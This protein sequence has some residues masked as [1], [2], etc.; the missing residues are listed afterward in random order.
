MGS[1]SSAF[2]V[3]YYSVLF[4][5]YVSF[6]SGVFLLFFHVGFRVSGLGLRKGEGIEGG[7]AVVL[8]V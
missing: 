4:Y 1:E 6:T 2:G 3:S 5:C 7:G 8:K